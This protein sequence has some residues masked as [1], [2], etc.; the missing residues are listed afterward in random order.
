MEQ[1]LILRTNAD[2]AEMLDFLISTNVRNKVTFPPGSLIEPPIIIKHH[3]QPID[4]Q[5]PTLVTIII[6][7]TLIAREDTTLTKLKPINFN[8]D[9]IEYDDD[10]I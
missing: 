3:R 5:H 9:E 1:N 7:M 6:A 4:H 10:E 2:E 8:N